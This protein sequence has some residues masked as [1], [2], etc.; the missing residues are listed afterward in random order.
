MV[1]RSR[2]STDTAMC[3]PRFVPATACTSSRI[4]VWT[5]ASISRARDVSI[6]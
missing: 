6:R 2:R 4:S 1:T 5:L 3:A